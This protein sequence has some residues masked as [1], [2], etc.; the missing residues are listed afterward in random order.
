[1]LHNS[2]G[3]QKF[4]NQFGR[5]SLLLIAAFSLVEASS[6]EDFQRVQNAAFSEYKDKKDTAF[7]SYLKSQWSEYN[8]FISPSLYKKVKPNAILPARVKPVL[9]RGPNIHIKVLK[10]F[11]KGSTPR[12][13]KRKGLEVDFFGALL[14]FSIDEKVKRARF[15]PQNKN[16]IINAFSIFASSDYNVLLHE[17]KRSSQSMKLN[18][19]GI[20]ML[21]KK[22]AEKT[23][24]DLDDEELFSWFLLNK[25]GFDIK[26]GI[27]AQHI[28]LLSRT[29]QMIYAAPKYK[30][31]GESYYLLSKN[32]LGGSIYTYSKSYPNATKA[33]D[34]SLDTL[35]LLVQKN[36]TKTRTFIMQKR[37]YHISYHYNKNLIDFM[38]TYPQVSYSVYF[39]TPLQ[40]E[41][42]SDIEASFKPYL[43]GKKMT[44]GLNFVLHFVQS[45]FKYERDQ[46][47]F[48]KEKVMFAQE[49]LYYDKS[50]CED[51]A[52]LYARLVK[53]LFGISVV[54]VKY[55]NHMAT[56]L[57]IPIVGASVHVHGKRY[58]IADPT[59]INANVGESMPK[60]RSVIPDKFIYLR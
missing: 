9:A 34:F 14:Y 16:G 36:Q 26:V 5:F 30:I 48:G 38:K 32:A 10:N 56:A 22:I 21:V 19:W 53:K 8:S 12:I 37:E 50:D 17:I 44:Y 57:H 3:E 23:F 18:D 59:Y 6:F 41:T 11:A 58:V 15:Y 33:V 35:P 60:Y 31:D 27:I 25:L 7:E 24:T 20:Y 2:L 45:A 46:Q 43:D 55:A 47:Q 29:K 4:F 39:S 42:L 13:K 49:T 51:R 54:G 1:M 52:T 40:K 28:A